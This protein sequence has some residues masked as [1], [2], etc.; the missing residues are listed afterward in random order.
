MIKRPLLLRFVGKNVYFV[1][2]FS[3]IIGLLFVLFFRLFVYGRVC[4][5]V[6]FPCSR[7]KLPSVTPSVG[8]VIVT[9][10]DRCSFSFFSFLLRCYLRFPSFLV[11]L[12][13]P[14]F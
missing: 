14:M 3:G 4:S 2:F 13:W 5:S 8:K 7:S 6:L 10:V 1:I 12:E 9:S 11:L